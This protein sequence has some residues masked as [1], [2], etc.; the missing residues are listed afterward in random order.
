MTKSVPTGKLARTRLASGAM[1]KA[2][3]KHLSHI[4]RR[5]FMS[6]ESSQQKKAQLDQ[7][8]AEIL[9]KALSQLRGTALKLAQ[10]LSLDN[11]YLPE[12][13]RKQLAMSCHQATPLGRPL[14]RK[15]F[16]QEF[17]R[18]PEK[19]FAEF[20]SQAFAAASLGQVHRAKSHAGKELAVKLQYPGIDITIDSDLQIM[21]MLLKRTAHAELLL[22]SLDE[23]SQR[24]QEEVDYHQEADNTEWFRSQL[25]LDP[26]RI[27][28]V[29]R[30]YSSKRI[31]TTTR[32]AGEHMDQWLRSNPSQ[33]QRNHFAQILYDLFVNSFYGLNALH[34]DPNPGN[35][36]FAEDGTL[37]LI[38]FGCVRHFS[39]DFVALMPQLLNAYLQ[40]DASAVLNCYEKLGMVVEG[41]DSGQQQEFYET[42]LKPFGDW[43]T[44]PFKAGRFDFSKRDSAYIKEGLELFG[45]LSQIKKI[46]TIANEF[47]YFDRTLFGLYQIF[48]RM[49]AEVAME[50]QWLI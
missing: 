18:A 36:L 23:I 25:Q 15:L 32:L 37:G 13:M 38:D 10:M 4:A 6:S 17:D 8:T 21:R 50:H 49:Q 24:L 26:V 41:L 5:P 1:L 12:P 46:D 2:G 30:D 27:P 20:D 29:C 7:Q 34:A 42:L 3:G 16:L 45:K 33:A 48:E 35:Y 14:I 47:I 31:I 22:S 44:K 11:H 39:A 40:Q 9:F 19:V 28:E 43:L